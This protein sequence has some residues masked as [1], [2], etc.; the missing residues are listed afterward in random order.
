MSVVAIFAEEKINFIDPQKNA[1][2]ECLAHFQIPNE[3][4][5]FGLINLGSKNGLAIT[6]K[7]IY[8]FIEKSTM[9]TKLVSEG[10][11]L[12]GGAVKGLFKPKWGLGMFKDIASDAKKAA[13]NLQNSWD[14]LKEKDNEDVRSFIPWENLDAKILENGST[15]GLDSS[16]A[17]NIPKSLS[18]KIDNIIKLLEEL[19]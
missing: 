1:S 6:A 2:P 12:L 8:V 16:V 18:G 17:I 15:L 10:A 11:G 7:G 5:A 3:A 13:E 19:K 14:K 9:A 4:V